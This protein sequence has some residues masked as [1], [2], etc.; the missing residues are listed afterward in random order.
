MKYY[1]RVLMLTGIFL[2]VL[3]SLAACSNSVSNGSSSSNGSQNGQGA[4]STPYVRSTAGSS[5]AKGT[6]RVLFDAAHAE[7]SGNAD[8]II[9]TSMPDPL[10]ENA[11][12]TRE[13]DWTGGI[14]AWGVALLQ[15]NRY[16]LKTN[17]RPLTYHNNSNALDLGNFDVLVLPEPN[18]LFTSS[19][20]MAILNF[21]HAGGGLFVIADHAG[22]DRNHYGSDSPT[23][24]NDVMNTGST[25]R[26]AFGF[27]FDEID[28]NYDNPRVLASTS[29]PLLK[30]PFG[31][32]KGSI[33]RDG[34]TESLYPKVNP[35]VRGVIYR[36]GASA[37]SEHGAFVTRSAYGSGRIV[38]IGDS[39]AIDDG[40]CSYNKKCFDGWHDPAAQDDILILNATEW[41]A[42]SST[43]GSFNN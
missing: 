33:I 34:T 15:S 12:P 35:A 14:S 2:L 37:G 23:I 8:W 29:D 39:S 1:Q 43:N 31:Q 21:V 5:T 27:Q 22:S 24:L 9:S 6:R 3:A 40:S 4:D 41:L 26:N 32:A 25:T 7:T 28:I 38:A 16:A 11:H 20:K 36:K 30:G 17:T 10:K 13:D 18:K 42:G 19:E